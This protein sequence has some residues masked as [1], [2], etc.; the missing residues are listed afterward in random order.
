MTG[1][2]EVPFTGAVLS[3]F[4]DGAKPVSPGLAAR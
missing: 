3:P 1:V 4:G 2:P